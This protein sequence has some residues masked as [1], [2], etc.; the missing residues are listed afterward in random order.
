MGS[1]TAPERA[2]DSVEMAKI[3]FGEEFVAENTVL[4]SLINVNSPLV[5]DATMLGALKVYARSN[6]ATII[7]P[8][9]LQGAMSPVTG[10][11]T[12]AQL[13]AEVLAGLAFTQLVR[14]GAPVVF[15][16][17]GCTISMR[18][19]APTFGT[20]E[21]AITLFAAAQ[22]AR[23][24]GVP[25]R[26]GGGPSASIIPDAQAGYEAA[27]GLLTTLLAGVNF[28][29]H[30]AGLIEGGLAMSYEKFILDADQCG[31]LLKGARGL[32]LSGNGQAMDTI[33]EVGPGNHYLGAAHTLS[34]C[35]DAVYESFIS[36]S[37]AYEQWDA[38]GR[39][40]AAQRANK[41]WKKLLAEYEPPPLDPA[42][43]E[44]LKDYMARRKAE[45]PDRFE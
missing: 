44:A 25:F 14:P 31:M 4:L 17:F 15:G 27:N 36:E 12:L 3:V 2:A 33:R 35:E 22:L 23:R 34:N 30:A 6:Q 32:D 16:S 5:L 7:T 28:C 24:L 20:P 26:S 1:V 9:I 29:L 40:D 8:F 41:M 43:D 38:E 19:G 39:S 45:L 21:S 13:Y 10:A 42:T 11:G 37:K 18:S